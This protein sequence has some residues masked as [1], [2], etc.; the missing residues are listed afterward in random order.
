MAKARTRI[1]IRK[2]FRGFDSDWC[3]WFVLD[4]KTAAEFCDSRKDWGYV[5]KRS[6]VAL[7]KK[8]AAQMSLPI[9]VDGKLLEE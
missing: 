6:A 7:A 3:V 8:R 1:E 4:G 5:H 9:Y 2:D